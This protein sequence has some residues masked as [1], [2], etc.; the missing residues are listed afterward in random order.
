MFHD[1]QPAGLSVYG[2]R[3]LAGRDGTS[4]STLYF[5]N[6]VDITDTIKTNLLRN[7][8]NSYT[9]DGRSQALREYQNNDLIICKVG[10]SIYNNVYKIT[11]SQKTNIYNTNIISSISSIIS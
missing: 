2:E 4:G 9:L 3:G 5:V 7:I 10:Q 1:I 11:R 6:Y 8:Q